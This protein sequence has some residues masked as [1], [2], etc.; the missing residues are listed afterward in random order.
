MSTTTNGPAIIRGYRWAPQLKVRSTVAVFP[1]GVALL[2]QVRATVDG[3]VLT[4]LTTGVGS[5]VRVDDTTLTVIIDGATS[6]D[7][8]VTS[9]VFD[10]VRTDTTPDTHLGFTVTV[11][12]VQPVTRGLT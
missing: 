1:D 8:D 6:V 2:A 10:V 3:N 9:V 12:V 7:W 5:L 11:P 4:T